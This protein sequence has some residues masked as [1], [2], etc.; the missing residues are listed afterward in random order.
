MVAGEAW[1][2]EHEATAARKQ[3]RMLLSPLSAFHSAQNPSLGNGA[4]QIQGR[5]SLLRKTL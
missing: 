5:S 2:Q 1:W 3:R 4:T